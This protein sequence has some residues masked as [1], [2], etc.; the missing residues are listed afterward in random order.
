MQVFFAIWNDLAHEY[1]ANDQNGRI[2]VTCDGA[3]EP[4]VQAFKRLVQK[5]LNPSD[6]IMDEVERSSSAI[7][8]K[9]KSHYQQSEKLAYIAIIGRDAA[10]P[11]GFEI[12]IACDNCNVISPVEPIWTSSLVAY[13]VNLRV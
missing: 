7:Q 11:T 13:A 9:I 1:Q 6:V 3:F 8:S 2:L 12:H 5:R 10:S 4:E